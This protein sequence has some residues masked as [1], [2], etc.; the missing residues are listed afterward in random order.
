MR[1]FIQVEDNKAV[2]HPALEENLIE[3]FGNVPE[4][5]QSFVLVGRPDIGPY[6]VFLSDEPTYEKI[7]GIWTDVWSFRELT[8]EEKIQK[9]EIVKANWAKNASGEFASWVFDEEK[10]IFVP[11]NNS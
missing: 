5:W 11:P 9:Q 2:S 10:C 7:D 3:A 1:L 6:K 4:N 8:P